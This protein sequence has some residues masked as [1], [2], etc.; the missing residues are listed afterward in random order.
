MR[1]LSIYF[2]LFGLPAGAGTLFPLQDGNEWR[3]RNAASGETIVV[4]VTTPYHIDGRVYHSLQGYA[5]ER[6]YVREDANG[7]LLSVDL[8]T[9]RE[10]VLVSFEPSDRSW[11][12][13]PHRP[14]E[15]EGQT[16]TGR[17][18]HDGPAAPL[19]PVVDIRYRSFGCADQGVERE[20]FAENI[21]MVRR[22][23]STIAGPRT[24][25]LVFARV[26]KGT[27]RADQH[28]QFTAT[29]H[30]RAG[31]DRLQVRLE[32]NLDPGGE[33]RLTFPTSQQ[34][35]L[36]LR[37]KEDR[38]LWRWSA[39]RFFTQAATERMVFR[40]WI[41]DVEIPKPADAGDGEF[42]LQAW[43]TTAEPRFAVS[44]WFRISDEKLVD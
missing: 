41:I 31:Q 1:A 36:V 42:V 30:D 23:E 33:V 25:D 18:N 27:I 12:E 2:A 43:L 44:T 15:Q 35:E 26:G 38:E 40:R 11:W 3:Y 21:G 34:Y 39:D 8:E 24:Y 20:Q 10:R 14:C 37:D 5:D 6:L 19:A 4:R 9:G 7:N 16:Q 32:L 22:V 13:A 29:V 17:V 28:G